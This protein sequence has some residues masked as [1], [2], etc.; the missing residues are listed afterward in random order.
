MGRCGVFGAAVPEAAVD[1][2]GDFSAGEDDVGGH[3]QVRFGPMVDSVAEPAAVKFSPQR[4]FGCGVAGDLGLHLSGYSG[5]GGHRSCGGHGS[6]YR[7][8]VRNAAARSRLGGHR[9]GDCL[10]A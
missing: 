9:G 3:A 8:F 4:E 2:D 10:R 5:A 1:K 6:Q 7:V